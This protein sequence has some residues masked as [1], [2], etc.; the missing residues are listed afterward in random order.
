M[1]SIQNTTLREVFNCLGQR[2]AVT[3]FGSG[4]TRITGICT[5]SRLIKN[6]DLFIAI[7]GESMDGHD[8]VSQ[9]QSV[10]AA[11]VTSRLLPDLKVP[12]LLAR[13]TREALGEIALAYR[14]QL[15]VPLVSVAG[16]NGKTTVKEMLASIMLQAVGSEA[17]LSTLGNLN[18]DLGVPFTLFRLK[19]EHKMG[20]I[21]IGMNHPGEIAWIASLVKAQVALVNNAQREHQ[22]FM[23]TVEATAVENGASISAL[24]SNG[25]AVFPF[26]DKCRNIW[27]E[28]SHDRTRIE[29]GLVPDTSVA[30]AA[31]AKVSYVYASANSQTDHFEIFFKTLTGLQS[32]LA[33]VHIDGL[34]NVRNALAASACALALGIK[35]NVIAKGLAAFSP[36][37]GRLVRH[38]LLSGAHLIDD[39]YNANPDSVRAAI[40]ILASIGEPR[41]LVLGDMGEVGAH[42]EQF[43]QEVGEFA[44]SQGIQH[45]L[46]LGDATKA[47]AQAAGGI[48]EH[49]TEVAALIER[50]RQLAQAPAT[51]LVKG[52][53]FMKME[54][55]VQALTNVE[56]TAQKETRHVA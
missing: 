11:V 35:L 34:H 39:S 51:V 1:T 46:L 43:H 47:S 8:F 24:D 45:V 22:E 37:K 6:G 30:L 13:D 2:H 4:Q 55:V 20:A 9:V 10:A 14:K 50:A 5:D 36:A 44:A 18:N 12:V 26:D 38:Q 23:A 15:S 53:R 3:L 25:I 54:R 32:T 48:A 41:V 16:S 52:S 21:E 19:Q 29:F 56:H 42:G 33:T 7:V 27:R 31:D 28:L 17:C 49:F 40:S